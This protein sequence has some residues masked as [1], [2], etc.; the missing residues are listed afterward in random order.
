LGRASV[1]LKENGLV[2]GAVISEKAGHAGAVI[3]EKGYLLKEK[4]QS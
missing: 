2:A 3:S 4:I 1:S